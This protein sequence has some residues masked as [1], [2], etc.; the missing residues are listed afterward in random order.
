MSLLN[1]ILLT[2]GAGFIGSHIAVNLISK[3]YK[4]SILDSYVNSKRT[5]IN[6]IRKSFKNNA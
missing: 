5:S 4:V 1:N 2:G 6:R 3:G